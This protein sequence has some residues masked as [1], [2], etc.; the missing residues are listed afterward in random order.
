[1]H[2]T[3]MHIQRKVGECQGIAQIQRGFSYVLSA[4]LIW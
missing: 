3:E 4:H 1:M 2:T